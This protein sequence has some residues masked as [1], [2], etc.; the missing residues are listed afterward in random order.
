MSEIQDA[1]REVG[2]A[3]FFDGSHVLGLIA[4]GQFQNPLDEGAD[5][6]A[7]S[8]H[9]TYF[10]P[11]RGIVVARGHDEDWWKPLDRAVFPGVTSNHH[12]FS[13]PSLWAASLEVREFGRAYAADV[14][15]NAQAFAAALDS[16][17]FHVAAKE[18]GYTRSH[19]V[20][21][22]VGEL[23]GGR[24]VSRRLCDEGIVTNMN[25]LPG[26]PRKNARNPRGIRL[27]VQEMTRFGMGEAEMDRIAEL[28]HRF[29]VG[30]ESI[31]DGCRALREEFREIRYGFSLADLDRAR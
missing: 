19:Q 1:C 4:G 25:L 18:L 6:L 20:A 5:L 10:G 29:L 7:G 26:E 11:Q 14:V 13:L 17:G 8:T 24:D 3:I 31:A 21:V 28:M 16:R 15:R 9:K 27:G 12:L 23:G 30:G 22:D 2:A